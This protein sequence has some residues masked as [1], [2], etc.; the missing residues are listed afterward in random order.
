MTTAFE[1]R[2]FG[3]SG[4]LVGPMG[5]ASS[6]GIGARGVER[7]YD[8]GIRFFLWGSR[9]RADFGRGLASVA[10]AHRAEVVVAIQ[11]YTRAAWL[12]R[13]SVERAL[14]ALGVDHVDYLGLAWWNTQP[15]ERILDAARALRE[16]GKVRHIMVSTHARSEVATI[17]GNPDYEG[18]MVRYNAA[19][20]GAE[21]DVFPRLD[22][23]RRPGIAAFT[24]TRWGALLDPRYTPPGLRT[25]RASDCYRFALSHPMVDVCL[26]GPKNEAE[27]SDALDT[28]RKGPLDEEE[29]AW[30]RAVGRSVRDGTKSSPRGVG[31]ST[32]DW[33]ARLGTGA[34]KARPRELKA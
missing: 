21:Q 20:P 9:R 3:P 24:A 23:A 25:P 26:S 8:E 28:V 2:T 12:M 31:M 15:R 1:P 17:A 7:A 11:T 29:L 6:Y 18:V 10:R 4:K 22:P 14:R 32:L 5:L 13:G 34:A 33:L 16:A 19:H 27:L 30:M